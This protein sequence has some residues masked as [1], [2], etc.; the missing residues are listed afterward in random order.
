MRKA[1]APDSI[2]RLV[3]T[4]DRNVASYHT[5][6]YNETQLRRDFLDPSFDAHGWDVANRL[7]GHGESAGPAAGGRIQVGVRQSPTGHWVQLC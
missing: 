6:A 5:S 4:F 2:R 3:E 7:R 1:T